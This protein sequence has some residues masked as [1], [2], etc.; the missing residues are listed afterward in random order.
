MGWFSW[1]RRSKTATVEK[2]K[3]TGR[4]FS[5]F[6][7]RRYLEDVP[8][9]LPKDNTEIQ[10]L[11][12]QH[13]VL[14]A[15]LRGNYAA[16]ITASGSPHDILDVGTGTGRWAIEMATLFPH[17]N[18]IGMDVVTPAA[19]SQTAAN[20]RRPENYVFLQG[21][22]LDGL[23]FPDGTFDLTHQ[24]LL[25]A[26]IPATRWPGVVA[27]LVRV[28]RPGGWVEMVEAVPAIGSP[29]M[30][31]L[32]EWLVTVSMGRGVDTRITN[33]IGDFLQQAGAQNVRF[34]QVDVPL[35]KVGGRE[36]VMMETNY[37]SL[38]IGIRGIVIAQG[39]A[40]GEQFDQT[41]ERARQEIA[42]GRY[43][44]PYFVAYGQRAG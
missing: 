41:M 43:V 32:R 27:D 31:Q 9:F 33:H 19:D 8:Y 4:R 30:N 22:V 44:W 40:T 39:L 21:S 2:P 35:G 10:R 24:R 5:V 38:H 20:D 37:F 18:V 23:P 3:P 13:Y 36:G 7:G 26:A 29:A 12:F 15:I 28:T 1:F 34:R 14:R 17:A 6:G 11:D 25:V 16:P 42:A